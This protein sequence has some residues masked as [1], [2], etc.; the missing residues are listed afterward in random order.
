MIAAVLLTVLL[1][2]DLRLVLICLS[3]AGG[4]VFFT[5]ALMWVVGAELTAWQYTTPVWLGAFA[6]AEPFISRGKVR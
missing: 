6:L 5:L 4:T 3:C 2:R 1:L